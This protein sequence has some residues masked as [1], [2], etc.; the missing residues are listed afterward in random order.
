MAD[1]SSIY[2][3]NDYKLYLTDVL[4]VSGPHRGNRSKLAQAL[5]CQTGFISHVINGTAHFSLEHAMKISR[6][7]GHSENEAHYLI[8]LLQHARSGTPSLKQYFQK[9][10]HEIQNERRKIKVRLKTTEGLSREAQETYYSSWYY[11]AIHVMLSIPR[12]QDKTELSRHL[13]LPQSAVSECLD[14][15]SSV[16]LAREN[17][18]KWAIG[19]NRI[20]LAEGHPLI[21][22]HHTHWR[23]QSLA[24]LDR[25]KPE[26]LHFSGVYSFSEK[27]IDKIRNIFLLAIEQSEAVIRPSQEECAF[28]VSLDFFRI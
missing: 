23:L 8:L 14:F 17:R 10:I 15:L 24:S 20:H 25:K 21:S 9:Q 6:F 11:S 12:F 27:D 13:N 18:G 3:F 28:G 16:G 5:S 19:D 2:G 4:P 7:L 22:R 26:N 1:H